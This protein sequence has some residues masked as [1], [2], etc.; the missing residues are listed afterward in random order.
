MTTLLDALGQVLRE[1]RHALGLTQAELA[2]RSQVSLRFLG[3]LEAGQGNI[4]VERLATVA[5]ALSLPVSRLFAQAE[6]KLERG[7]QRHH[8]GAPP[9]EP[10]HRIALLGVRGAGKSTVGKLLSERLHVPF[11][12]LDALVEKRAGLGLSALFE[13]HGEELFR[14]LEGE[15]LDGLLGSVPAFVVA[16]GGSLVTDQAAYETIRAA[17]TTVWLKATAEDHWNRVIAQGDGRPMRRN[18]RAMDQLRALLKTR[19]PLYEQ[20]EIVVNTSRLTP[21]EIVTTLAARFTGA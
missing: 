11:V 20:A 10:R 16:T 15:A 4:S 12:E 8:A 1:R 7:P 5:A 2:T 21:E 6:A 9:V 14:K 3:Q 19:T 17:C 13:L 18:P